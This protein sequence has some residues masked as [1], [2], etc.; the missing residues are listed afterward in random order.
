MNPLKN[1]IR[2]WLLAVIIGGISLGAWFFSG[3]WLEMRPMELFHTPDAIVILGGGDEARVRQGFMLSEMF[4]KVPVV[5][6]G[7]GGT[8]FA[9]LTHR[10]IP[11]DRIQYEPA[12]KTT[13]ENAILTAPILTQIHARRV[14]LVT[15]WFHALR[16]RRIF[17][18]Y[19][20]SRDFVV[21]FEHKPD[22]LLKWDRDSQLR[23]RFAILYNF[24]RYGVWSF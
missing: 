1:R 14:I 9:E 19:Q 23:E 16:A 18:K 3:G 12:A 7:D 20:P 8:I 13:V 11:S 21:S 15:N 24:L 22:P 5:V 10:G 17:E 6:T 4:P 2:G